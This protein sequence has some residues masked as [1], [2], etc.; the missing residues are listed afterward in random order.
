MGLDLSSGGTKG[1]CV[2]PS[3]NRCVAANVNYSQVDLPDRFVFKEV[4]EVVL[5]LGRGQSRFVRNS[6]KKDEMLGVI[7]DNLVRISGL[8]RPIPSVE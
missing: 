5:L 7:G 1:E 8:Q 6:G 2:E 4:V 3:V